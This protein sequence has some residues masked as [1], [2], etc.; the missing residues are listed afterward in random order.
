MLDNYAYTLIAFLG[1]VIIL[2]YINLVVTKTYRKLLAIKIEQLKKNIYPIVD[3]SISYYNREN[4]CMLKK[5]LKGSVQKNIVIERFIYHIENSPVKTINL[6]V[7]ICEEVGLVDFEIGK[8]R[9][10]DCHKVILACK[11]LGDLRSK[12]AVAA[13]KSLI[14]KDVLDLKY[15]VLMSISKIGDLDCLKEIFLKN[16]KNIIL[17]GRSLVEIADS[18]N[19]DKLEL[20]KSLIN[21]EDS[22]IQSIFIKSAGNNCMG[23]LSDEIVR[24]INGPKNVKIACIKAL[25][26]FE[27]QKYED[28]ILEFLK[29]REW[30]VRSAAAKSLGNIGTAKALK[31]LVV[32]ISDEEWWVRYNSAW[33]INKLPGGLES[34]GDILNGTDRFARDM[35]ISVLENTGKKEMIEN[36]VS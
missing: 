3:Q 33:S 5:I 16:P 17:S 25:G 15:N 31:P 30:E 24:Y 35:I 27:N 18:F 22:Y 9:S 2:L 28:I 23:S 13:I 29:D 12:K 7:K 11:T 20:Y 10:R 34:I 4:Y 6:I 1:I 21:S 8:L 36:R 14:E 32:A 19:G 26:Q